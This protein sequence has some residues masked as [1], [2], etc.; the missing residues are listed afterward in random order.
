MKETEH[1]MSYTQQTTSH[2]EDRSF[3]GLVLDGETDLAITYWL[4]F[5][6][7]SGIFFV[8]GSDAVDKE[9]WLLY[10]GIVTAAL[11]DTFLLILGIKAAY[12]GP[13]LWKVMLRTSSIFMIINVLVGIP[14]LSFVH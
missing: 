6:A 10:H 14:T 13:Q 8:F 1:D 5:L 4:L 11:A 3:M 12:R 7:G 2:P 9:Q